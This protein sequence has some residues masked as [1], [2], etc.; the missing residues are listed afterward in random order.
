VTNQIKNSMRS[1]CLLILLGMVPLALAE[2]LC[3]AGN[4]GK[5]GGIGGTGHAEAGC[6]ANK[7]VE[8]NKGGIG[9]TGNL[10]TAD[11]IGGTGIIGVITDF[12][13]IWVNGI[14][15][16]YDATTPVQANDVTMAADKLAL[17]QVVAVEATGSGNVMR[18]EQI[19]VLHVVTGSIEE[20]DLVQNQMKVLGQAIRV[21]SATHNI[22]LKDLKIGDPV[23]ISGLR[24]SHGT[25]VASRVDPAPRDV[26]EVTGR[27][28][29]LTNNSFNI[30][31][32]PVSAAAIK[33]LAVGREVRVAGT[34]DGQRFHAQHIK[35]EPVLPF[36][37]KIEQLSLQGYV[38]TFNRQERIRLG[39][40]VIEIPKNLEVPGTDGL[41]DSN[42]NTVTDTQP[43]M[44][45]HVRVRIDA[46]RRLVAERI[47]IERHGQGQ[48]SRHQPEFNSGRGQ[49]GHGG[50]DDGTPRTGGK[51]D[52]VEHRGSGKEDQVEKRNL[53]DSE[54]RRAHSERP[55]RPERPERLERLERL[56]HN[57]RAETHTSGRDHPEDD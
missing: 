37:G 27:V 12:G 47:E 46:D 14:R 10:A 17:G 50:R 56:E 41:N 5:T 22:A 49:K 23:R 36:D 20:I 13:S 6:I 19:T 2:S 42:P 45:V 26:M 24:E 28:D 54:D 21:T 57:D 52:R 15:V 7:Q 38:S 31:D 29:K 8:G 16:Q 43:E 44:R 25:I 53:L 4:T 30:G 35:I 55:E 34:W 39:A 51:E 32:L 33:G 40:A 1:I 18:A 3:N 9:G 48:D 11:G